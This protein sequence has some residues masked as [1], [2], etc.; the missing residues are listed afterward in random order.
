MLNVYFNMLIAETFNINFAKNA[1]R[2][3][4]KL[5]ACKT[6]KDVKNLVEWL[7]A[8]YPNEVEEMVYCRNCN[9]QF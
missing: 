1:G 6:K 4:K 7:K 3:D 2:F 8:K 9:G 5:A